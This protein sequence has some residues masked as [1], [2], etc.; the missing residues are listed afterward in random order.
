MAFSNVF[1]NPGVQPYT[2]YNQYGSQAEKEAA[3]G[4]GYGRVLSAPVRAGGGTPGGTAGA[5]GGLPASVF[6]PFKQAIESLTGS[7]GDAERLFQQGKRRTLSDI[8]M[9]SIQSGLA[10]TLNMG[11]ASATYDVENRPGFNVGIAG[12][13]AGLLSTLGQTAAGLYGTDV[14]ASTSRYGVDAQTAMNNANNALKLYLS[15][16]ERKYGSNSGGTSPAPVYNTYYGNPAPA[17][18]FLT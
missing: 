18:S 2:I 15:E 7:Q 4:L 11:A 6:D 1:G 5:T 14:G 12:Q 8:A 3:Q 17:G 9:N 10:N 13:K 16:L